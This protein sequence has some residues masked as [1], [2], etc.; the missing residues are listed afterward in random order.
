MVARVAVVRAIRIG[1]A[2]VQR[3]GEVQMDLPFARF[4]GTT[5]IVVVCGG[6]SS[7][8]FGGS[9]PNNHLTK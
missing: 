8:S 6:L 2:R 9:A 7:Y 4:Q 5:V 1:D 3:E